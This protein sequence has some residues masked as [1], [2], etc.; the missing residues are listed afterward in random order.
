[1]KL[2][3]NTTGVE[4]KNHIKTSKSLLNIGS[5]KLKGKIQ[6]RKRKVIGLL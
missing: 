5:L 2:G 3:I 1:M 4:K 6:N